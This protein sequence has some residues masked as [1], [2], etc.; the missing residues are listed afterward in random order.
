MAAKQLDVA[1]G[2]D[3]EIYL[4]RRSKTRPS[5]AFERRKA[6]GAVMDAVTQ[7]VLRGMRKGATLNYTIGK[8][9]YEMTV[10]PAKKR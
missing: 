1:V 3:G 8:R 10:K 7:Y 2:I 4:M 9:T 5:F 6:T